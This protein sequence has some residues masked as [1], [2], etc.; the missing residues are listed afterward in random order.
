MLTAER[1]KAL[2]ALREMTN[3]GRRSTAAQDNAAISYVFERIADLAGVNE[4]DELRSAFIP[5][6]GEYALYEEEACELLRVVDWLDSISSADTPLDPG[7]RVRC[8]TK[9]AL[10][11]GGFFTL[12]VGGDIGVV[13][14]YD[15]NDNTV[16][17]RW[18]TKALWHSAAEV[19]AVR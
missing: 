14:A 13:E 8:P 11:A 9:T 1:K 19:E 17:V 10:G 6:D 7:T 4:V 3:G 12:K 15:H 5:E 16:L 18:G 2:N